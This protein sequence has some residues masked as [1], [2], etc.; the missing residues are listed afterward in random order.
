MQKSATVSN[1][2]S[3]L[4]LGFK[5]LESNTMYRVVLSRGSLDT[6]FI[7]NDNFMMTKEHLIDTLWLLDKKVQKNH[8]DTVQFIPYDCRSL[9]VIVNVSTMDI[10]RR[11]N[12]KNYLKVSR[13]SVLRWSSHL[14]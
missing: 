6:E 2:S 12:L 4:K 8:Y 9:S 13:P 5:E 14:S 11:V 1:I 7:T 3:L 10:R